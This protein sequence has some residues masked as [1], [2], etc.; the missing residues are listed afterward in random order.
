MVQLQSRR[1]GCEKVWVVWW[2]GDFMDGIGVG[3]G[4]VNGIVI[5][6]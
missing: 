6:I 4:I 2:E 1:V 5:D 3:I